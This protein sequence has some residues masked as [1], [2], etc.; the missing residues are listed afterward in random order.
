MEWRG[1]VYHG[2]TKKN[3]SNGYGRWANYDGE[4]IVEAEWKK[5][6]K[7]GITVENIGRYCQNYSMQ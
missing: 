3:I 1:G 5:G 6:V 4:V 2:R 7:N